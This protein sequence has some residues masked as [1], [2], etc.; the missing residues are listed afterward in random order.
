MKLF[1]LLLLVCSGV[2][3][4]SRA[5]SPVSSANPTSQATIPTFSFQNIKAKFR[6]NYFSETLGPSIQKW[7]DNE[8]E[9]DGSV[10]REPMTMYHSLNV[11][12]RTFENLSLFMS[13]RISTVIGDRNDIRQNADPHV[14]V[15]DD[16]QFGL[17]YSFIS[18]PTFNY[19]QTLTHRAPFSTKSRNENI[20]SQIEWQHQVT[21]AVAPAWRVLHW[22]NFRYYEF[23]ENATEERH[24]VNFRNIL[25]YTIN[26]KW[27]AQLSYE[28]DMQ[29]RNTNDTSRPKYR[30]ANFMKRYHSY[31]SV[32]IGYSP[33]QDF[34]MIPFVRT[35]DERNIR[36][37]TTVVGL[38]LL[39]KI[40]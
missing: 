29:H 12:F 37:E 40:I 19:A 1:L 4:Q 8:I 5:Q 38:L 16:W 21:W 7:Q 27:D 13:P 20:D 10:K 3:A 39:G 15:M 24:R 31:T 30:D 17:Y 2:F 32:G 14:I 22:T 35:V 34:T 25:N 33:T 26:D 36:N 18:N 11:R 6:I 9:D 28:F 23:N